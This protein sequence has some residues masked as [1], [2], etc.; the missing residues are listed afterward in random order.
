[1]RKEKIVNIVRKVRI[2]AVMIAGALFVWYIFDLLIMLAWLFAQTIGP[3]SNQ[4]VLWVLFII[5]L[6]WTI[7][8]GA[9]LFLIE[10]IDERSA[11]YAFI[12]AALLAVD[13]KILLY[14]DITP[15]KEL[16]VISLA[17]FVIIAILLAVVILV[18]FLLM[19]ARHMGWASD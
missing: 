4:E 19:L 13:A 16:P 3:L 18:I 12:T 14:L 9:M 2:P 10:L 6:I 5:E 1:M 17:L 15:L 7:F 8:M 11:M